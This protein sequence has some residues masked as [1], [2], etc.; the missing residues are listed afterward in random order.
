MATDKTDKSVL[1]VDTTLRDAHQCLWA[2][3]M[4]TAMMLPICE[5]LNRGGYAAIDLMGMVQFDVCVR[6]LREDPWERIRRIRELVTEAPLKAY[7]R[8]KSLI[9]FDVLP[10]DV[11]ALWVERLV[12]NGIGMVAAFDALADLDN[13][14]PNLL[15]AKR[16][17]AKTCGALVF[18]ESPIH[19]DAFYSG[20]AKEL[21]ERAEVDWLMV[22]DSG[23]LLT[24]DRIRTLIPELRKVIGNTPIELHSHCMTGMAPLVY[25]EA[26]KLGVKILDTSI[27]PL[28]NGPAQPST[29]TMIR[30]LQ[31]MGYDT[32]IDQQ[33]VDE[34]SSHWH[35]VAEQE[36]LPKGVPMAYDAFHYEHQ[37]PGGMLTNLKAQLDA[38]GLADKYDEVLHECAQIRQELAWPIMVT[39]FAQLVGTQAVMNIVHGERYRVVPDEVKKY[40]LGYYGKLPAPVDPDILDRIVRN[41]SDRIKLDPPE[42]PPMVNT[43]RKK[44]PSATDDERLLRFCLAGR[45]VDL[46]REAGPMR[47]DIS[48]YRP[49]PQL[50]KELSTRRNWNS[51]HITGKGL[52]ITLKENP[53]SVQDN[54]ASLTSA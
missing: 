17:G 47:T 25:L 13:I 20:K 32:F 3:R 2:T 12:A 35:T 11:N 54:G 8:S 53:G 44:Y 28:S 48:I 36:G 15:L 1:F 51:I 42:Q 33:I 27:D 9:G 10:D 21:V 30:N 23:G 38:S 49:L 16:L 19:T 22:K 50:L 39:P 46:I 18:C 41:G 34:I 31:S 43:L 24:V 45:E 26:V 14:V 52:N 4:T 7:M 37:M 40:A 5:Q 29:Q 6:Y